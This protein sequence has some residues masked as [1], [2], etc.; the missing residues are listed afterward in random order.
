MRWPLLLLPLL[1]KCAGISFLI[2]TY[3][4]CQPRRRSHIICLSKGRRVSGI[5]NASLLFFSCCW[6]CRRRRYRCSSCRCCWLL[7]FILDALMPLLH[8]SGCCCCWYNTSHSRVWS[9]HTRY[10]L[11]WKYNIQLDIKPCCCCCCYNLSFVC[12]CLRLLQDYYITLSSEQGS[13]WASLI[14]SLPLPQFVRRR[15]CCCC[16]LSKQFAFAAGWCT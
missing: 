13:K 1:N 15:C 9:K 16:C 3:G 5:S 12:Y 8:R 7:H 6:C 14:A 4:C 10:S 2:N 11:M